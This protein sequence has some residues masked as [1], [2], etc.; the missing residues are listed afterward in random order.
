[1]PPTIRRVT[2]ALST[3]AR[4]WLAAALLV[5]AIGAAYHNSFAV[6]FLYDDV[7][8]IAAN[9][10]IQKLWPLGPALTPPPNLTSSGRPIVNLTLAINYA[11]SGTDVAS[12]HLLN[13]LIHIAAALTLFGVVRR[14]LR[15]PVLPAR[16][17]E[18]ATLVGF[19]VAAVWALHPLQTESVT[20]IVQRAESLVGLFYLLTLYCFIR[21]AEAGEGDGRRQDLPP[22]RASG[23]AWS[24]G[25]VAC[26]L[27]GM[28]SKE[29]MVSAPLLVWLYDRT[30]ISGTFA[31]SWRRHGRLL[32]SLAATWGVLA[33]LV[34]S[35]GATRDGSAGFGQGMSALTYLVTQ[36]K[37]VVTYLRLTFYPHPL[38]FDYG[39]ATLGGRAALPY[40]VLVGLVLAGVILAVVRRPVAG[41]VGAAFFAILAPSSSIVPIVTETMAEHRM[42]LP[43]AAVITF[44]GVALAARWGRAA[45][46]A[47]LI[48]AVGFGV[49]TERRNRAYA[50]AVSLWSDV[51]AKL[52]TNGRAHNQLGSALAA[53]GRE[54]EAIAQ[55]RQALALQPKL[56]K[57]HFNY[58]TAL[59]RSG[60]VRESLAEFEAALALARDDADT[61]TN[62]GR[63]LLDAGQ[64][65]LAIVHYRVALRIDPH[66]AEAHND[67]GVALGMGGQLPEAIREFEAAL[68]DRPEYADA[69]NNLGFAL[70]QSGRVA[71]AVPRFAAAIACA[72][73]YAEAH[74]NLARAYERLGVAPAAI[75][76]Y[77]AVIRL[78]PT[79]A[80]AH[81]ALA[82]VLLRVGRVAEGE[83][84]LAATLRLDPAHAGARRELAMLRAGRQAADRS[85]SPTPSP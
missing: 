17:G 84:E 46:C 6:P 10:S 70:V 12:Y 71:D 72:P 78:A 14:T 67:L 81:F 24:V 43:L 18:H 40:L 26:C 61:H 52:P 51:V 35:T 58:A 1:M 53:A 60:Q 9:A 19:A 7:P 8:A 76:Q 38:I 29:V 62:Y 15:R 2:S 75:A 36:A 16:C 56:A 77:R 68:R 74:N 34:V 54:A 45:A 32:T 25:C 41:F 55:Y 28:A 21:A 64:P 80:E 66:F 48:V 73:G 13:L 20:Y 50:S 44:V 3:R 63:A 79:Y 31:A 69:L 83:D 49:L 59:Y 82:G 4:L 57:A 39:F 47:L 85:V 42:Y 11:I 22:A 37:A 27:L 5:G 23:L 30:F 65:D 33:W